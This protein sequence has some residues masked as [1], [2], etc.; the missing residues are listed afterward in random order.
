MSFI[1]LLVPLMPSS[2]GV[3]TIALNCMV[4][5]THVESARSGTAKSRPEQAQKLSHFFVPKGSMHS[6]AVDGCAVTPQVTRWTVAAF[7]ATTGTGG[8]ITSGWLG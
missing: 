4:A 1:A 3:T 8:S 6:S 7:N 5:R 2:T